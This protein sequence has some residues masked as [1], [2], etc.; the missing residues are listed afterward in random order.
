MVA[1]AANRLSV[2]GRLIEMGAN[3][4]R[5]DIYEHTALFYA[6]RNGHHDAVE[7]LQAAGAKVDD[8]SLHEAAR[9]AF[10]QI[11]ELLLENGHRRDF[12]SSLHADQASGRNALEELCR[13]ATPTGD[14]DDWNARI[15]KC[16][17]QLLPGSVEDLRRPDGKT[18][19]HL[20]FE[21]PDP[22]PITRALLDFSWVWENK[23]LHHS[24]HLYRDSHGYFYSLTKYAE[25][26]LPVGTLETREQLIALLRTK[27]CADRFYAH[28]I[29]QPEGAVGLPDDVALALDKHNRAEYEHQEAIKRQKDLAARNRAIEQEDYDRRVREDNERHNLLMRQQREQE[30][31]DLRIVKAKADAALSH[32]QSIAKQQRLALEDQRRLQNAM[33]EDEAQH[34]ATIRQAQQSSELNHK[35]ALA[36]QELQAVQ[37]RLDLEARIISNKES[38]GIRE[39]SR[40]E[41]MLRKRRETADYE[42]RMRSNGGY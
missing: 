39:Q 36:R 17:D 32:A 23:N 5:H 29:E 9:E 26:L 18:I 21:N 38:A 22:L 13:H 41:E 28:T 30:M 20:A 37:G 24:V 10:P 34:R 3:I 19:M 31:E 2:L 6:S 11:V 33:L 14:L 15:R 7:M 8:G 42:A 16:I 27:R 1:S 25:L 40:L 12:S 35:A 4:S